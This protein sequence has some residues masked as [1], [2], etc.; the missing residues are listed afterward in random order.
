MERSIRNTFFFFIL[1]FLVLLGWLTYIQVWAASDLNRHPR[2][3]RALERQMRTER[4]EILTADG[5]RLAVN[6]EEGPYYLREYPQGDLAS[7]WL[8]YVHPRY[9]LAGLEAAYNPELAGEIEA[10]AFRNFMDAVRGKEKSGA[11]L[12]LTIDSRVQRTAETALGERAGA[13]IALDPATGA[14]LA[15]ASSPRYDPRLLSQDWERLSATTG[16]LFVNR[17]LRGLYPPGSVFKVLVAAAALEEGALTPETIFEDQGSW[18]AGGFVVRNYGGETF[19]RHNAVEAFSK[20]INT[21]FAKIG[22]GLGATSLSDYTQA[23]GWGEDPGLRLETEVSQFPEA[24]AMDAAHVAQVSF[25]QGEV[26]AT[27]LHMA[28]V[29]AAIASDGVIMRPYLVSEV[30][31]AGGIVLRRAKPEVWKGPVSEG[32]AE[33]LRDMMREV[34]VSGTGTAAALSG[35]QVAGKTGTAEVGEGEAH[36]WFVGFAPAENPQVLVATVVEH[37]GTGGK[38]AAPIVRSVLQ[39]ALSR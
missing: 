6:R 5:V 15:M 16:G 18:S 30:K 23:F 25:G 19:G 1:L 26:L 28:L 33:T 38:V 11:D 3:T 4:G 13:V 9:G 36:A 39:E 21:T 35:V 31:D 7:P 29:T 12:V 17:A 32:T 22:A 34:V 10:T 24:G 20:S 37:G 14:V 27:P 8:G 2:N